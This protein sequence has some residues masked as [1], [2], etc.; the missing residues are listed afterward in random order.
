MFGQLG[1]TVHYI[2]YNSSILVTLLSGINLACL[3]MHVVQGQDG[4]LR[5]RASLRRLLFSQLARSF[6]AA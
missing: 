3:D 4:G 1:L 6:S 5:S 2:D